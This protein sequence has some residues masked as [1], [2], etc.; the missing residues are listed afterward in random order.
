MVAA[1]LSNH[2]STV[3]TYPDG[4]PRALSGEAVLLTLPVKPFVH[5]KPSLSSLA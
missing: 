2:K 4:I 5:E 3:H 1:I